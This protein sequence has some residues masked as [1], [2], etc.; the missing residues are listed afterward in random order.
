LVELLPYHLDDD[1]RQGDVHHA[2]G[3]ADAIR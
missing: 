3:L 1:G 2:A